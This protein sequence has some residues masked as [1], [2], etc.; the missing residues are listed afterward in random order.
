M[1]YTNTPKN[2]SEELGPEQDS[3]EMANEREK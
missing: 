1:N 3:R 2:T